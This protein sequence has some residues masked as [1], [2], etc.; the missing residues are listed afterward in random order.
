MS[1]LNLSN[2]DRNWLWL[3]WSLYEVLWSVEAPL[4]VYNPLFS[5]DI[6]IKYE[7]LGCL[8]IFPSRKFSKKVFT[9]HKFNLMHWYIV[10]YMREEFAWLFTSLHPSS[11]LIIFWFRLTKLKIAYFAV[12]TREDLWRPKAGLH[13]DKLLYYKALNHLCE[14]WRPFYDF[15][16]SLLPSLRNK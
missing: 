8:L 14:E 11:R 5:C 10:W 2:P 12:K 4:H 3:A 7:V 16:F 9:L 6:R 1:F 15:H 13:A